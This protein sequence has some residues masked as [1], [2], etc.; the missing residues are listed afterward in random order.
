[1]P[2]LRH[3]VAALALAAIL[4][5]HSALAVEFE[6]ARGLRLEPVAT[7]LDNPAWIGAPPGDARLFVVEQP[8]RILILERGRLR[9]EPFLDIRDR[10]GFGGE[11][12][13]LSVAFHPRYAENG[14]LF[15]NYTDRNGDTR[16]ERYTAGPDP[17]LADER[18]ARLVLTVHQ[19]YRNHNGGLVMFG[20]DGML[21]IGMGDG[22]SG[23]DPEGHGQDRG[24]LLGDLLRVD[25]DHGEPYAVPR[26][27]PF[28]GRPGLR[29]EIWAW[30]LRNP[31]RFCF[32]PATS[33]LY[34]AD[35][36]QGRFEEID[37]SPLGAAGLNYGWNRMEGSHCFS[38]PAC[39]RSGLALPVVE[40][41]HTQGCSITGGFV[42]RGSAIPRLAGHYFFADYCRGWVRSF[43]YDHG[44]VLDCRQWSLGE[45]GSVTSF[46]EDAAGELYIL[47]QEGRV[48]RLAPAG[49]P[50]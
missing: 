34:I 5:P 31:W 46:G 22:G 16:V 50:G 18:S 42:Y 14:W 1:M 40:Y 7:G 4:A 11:R 26:D 21:W 29:P 9:R 19:P 36:G 12:G 38:P 49:P 2:Q 10:V 17:D 23:G 6:H 37:V 43:R 33:L 28:V 8:G 15:V 45:V 32:D 25:V 20:P 48:L 47:T 35:V 41:D 30:G 39:D 24:D 44:R 13:L 3:A 27:N